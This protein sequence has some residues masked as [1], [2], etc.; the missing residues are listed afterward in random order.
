MAPLGYILHQIRAFLGYPTQHKK[1]GFGS[2]VKRIQQIQNQV[3][4][5]L[6]PQFPLVPG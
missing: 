2:K 5:F 3:C 4:V 6:N 1:G